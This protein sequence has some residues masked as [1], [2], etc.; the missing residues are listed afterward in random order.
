MTEQLPPA[1]SI[2]VARDQLRLARR[3]RVDERG[4]FDQFCKRV[5]GLPVDGVHTSPAPDSACAASLRPADHGLDAVR[6]AY[7]T[8]VMAVPHYDEAYGDPYRTHLAT[9]LGADLVRN[10]ARA[11]RL[12]PQLQSRL[13]DAASAARERRVESIRTLDAEAVTLD[14]TEQ[15]AVDLLDALTDDATAKRALDPLEQRC[16]RHVRS[17][18]SVLN[19]ESTPLLADLYADDPGVDPVLVTLETVLA[20][21]TEWTATHG[22]GRS[23]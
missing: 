8:T 3:V 23:D 16:R 5:E 14:R 15:L 9:E 7:E 1:D 21:M 20:R 6:R 12:T 4:A 2:E 17:R 19:D 13:V 18:Q 22:E 10:L 11:T